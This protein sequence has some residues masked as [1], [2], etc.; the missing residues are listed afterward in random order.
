MHA[1]EDSGLMGELRRQ[2]MLLLTQQLPVMAAVNSLNGLL[3]VSLFANSQTR[4]AALVWLGVILVASA[5]QMRAWLKVRG[6]P[7]PATVSGRSLERAR[8][9][10]G[11]IGLAWGSIAFF[12]WQDGNVYSEMFIVLVIAGMAA[13]TVSLL[14]PIPRV[15]VAF[16][17]AILAPLWAR[18]FWEGGPMHWVIAALAAVFAFAL[19]VGSQ[20]SYR[21]MVELIRSSRAMQTIRADLGDAIEATSDAIGHFDP[22]MKLIA[23]NSRFNEWFKDP[24]AVSGDD[25]EG[26]IRAVGADRWV[27]S[28]LLPTS[29]GG[30]VSVHTDITDLKVR[31]EEI[32]AAR[33]SAEEGSRAKSAFIEQVGATLRAPMEDV[34]AFLALEGRVPAEKRKEATAQAVKVLEAVSDIADIA[35]IDSQSY[36]Y[37]FAFT[38]ARTLVEWAAQAASA[39]YGK[40]RTARLQINVHDEI[41]DL[42]CDERALKRSLMHLIVNALESTPEDKDVGVDVRKAFDGQAEICVWDYG[43]GFDPALLERVQ[44][45]ANGLESAALSDLGATQGIGL[46]LRIVSQVVQRHRGSLKILSE[47]TL[48]TFAYVKLPYRTSLYAT[49]SVLDAA[50]DDAAEATDAARDLSRAASASP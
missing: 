48:G 46:G 50:N 43:R 36:E 5:F 22:D 6:K 47:P 25:A 3:V 28:K 40:R 31:E 39:R 7:V 20:R 19:I 34:V 17:L 10:S 15:A 33:L 26:R 11:V 49:P 30:F 42:V 24:L 38:D 13:G 44:R 16:L 4:L 23:A 2:Q 27:V 45:H 29:R 37:R 32:E 9:L 1:V 8:M 35:T 41:V 18:L 14:N 12:L 21:H